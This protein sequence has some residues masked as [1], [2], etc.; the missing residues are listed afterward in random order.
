M[1]PVLGYDLEPLVA[2][3]RFIVENDDLLALESLVGKFNIFDAL[4]V[5]GVEIRHSNF[6][7]FI[8]D[9]GESHGQGDL[10]LKALLMDLLKAAPEKLRPLS[11]IEIDGTDLQGVEVKREWNHIDLLLT[12]RQPSFVIAI[13]N[14]VHSHEHSG[15][16]SRYQAATRHHYP[17]AR[18]LYIYLTARGEAPSEDEWVPY[19]YADLHRV[20]TRVRTAN[21]KA[22]G[23][24]I[25]VFLNHYLELIGARFMDD[26]RLDELCQ[27]I[28]KNHRQA[29]K[30][31]FER[32]GSPTSGALAE[33]EA[34]LQEDDR[35][36]MFYR[37]GNRIDFVPKAWLDWLPPIG[38]DRKEEP[39]SWLIL[40]LELT[41]DGLDFYAE[42]RK[43]PDLVM[44]KK[45]IEALMSQAQRFG[46]RHSGRAVTDNYTRVSGR[47]HLTRWN[48]GDEPDPNEVR[49]AAKKKLDE[50]FP[51][52]ADIPSVLK[53]IL[54]GA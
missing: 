50:L 9:P 48:E 2:L 4:G 27:R 15:Q 23:E 22:I 41:D 5:A 24:E 37:S 53:P 43:M 45:I 39:R 14:K 32:A 12:C 20:L 47:D 7:S 30:L 10:F 38:L 35:W 29:L 8:L 6:L 49:V 1:S 51:K 21:H 44:R 46:F 42:V 18:A 40:R 19:S 33:V 13:E 16:L 3:E 34:V 11:P 17:S 52:L 26:A 36:H 25:R 54:S 28:Y 31:I